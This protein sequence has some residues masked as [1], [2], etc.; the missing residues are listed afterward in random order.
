MPQVKIILHAQDSKTCIA[1]CK[2]NFWKSS[3]VPLKNLVYSL[4]TG[5]SGKGKVLNA[6]MTR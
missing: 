5:T 3:R 1:G 6:R 2:G 4:C